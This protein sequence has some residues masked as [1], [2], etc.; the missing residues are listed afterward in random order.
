[1][2]SETRDKKMAQVAVD[3]SEPWDPLSLE[4]SSAI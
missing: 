4:I 1:M 3:I 2:K